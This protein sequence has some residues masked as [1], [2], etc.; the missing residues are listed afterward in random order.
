[1]SKERPG[2]AANGPVTPWNATSCNRAGCS[3]QTATLQPSPPR[4]WSASALPTC[5]APMNDARR[6]STAWYRRPAT[7]RATLSPDSRPMTT[8][9]SLSLCTRSTS[10]L[11]PPGNL[12][13]SRPGPA[14]TIPAETAGAACSWP[15]AGAPT[16]RIEPPAR[17]SRASAGLL[18]SA[19]ATGATSPGRAC[20]RPPASWSRCGRCTW[21][22]CA[23]RAPITAATARLTPGPASAWRYSTSTTSTCAPTG[24]HLRPRP[25]LT[26]AAPPGCS[27]CACPTQRTARTV[28]R[29]AD[30]GPRTMAPAPAHSAARGSSRCG[31]ARCGRRYQ[32]RTA[33]R[34]AMIRCV[35]KSIPSAAKAK[36]IAPTTNDA[37]A[38]PATPF[39]VRYHGVG[40]WP[41]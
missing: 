24:R 10:T 1:M 37:P 28:N 26:K 21:P 5:C 15:A 23:R 30:S 16:V 39:H 22:V 25:L 31:A 14:G 12:S 38:T 7:G 8:S 6:L 40:S 17:R 29:A 32:L 35:S 13:G 27:A 20:R 11:S 4:S 41:W 36:N 33:P 18:P 3:G 34:G 19:C 9:R 2:R